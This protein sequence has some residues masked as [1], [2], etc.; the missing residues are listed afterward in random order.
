MDRP[1][2]ALKDLANPAIG[3]NNDS[4]LWKALALVRL[5]KWADA[6]EKFKNVEFAVPCLPIDLQRIAISDA[7]RAAVEVKDYS[8]AAQRSSD[9]DVIGLPD[10]M[11]PAIAVL[12]G[13]LAEALGHDMDALDNY[14]HAVESPDRAAAA[15]PN[16]V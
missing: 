1:A 12:R 4:Q 2:L 16:P 9:L 6:R 5:G 15:E 3:T 8:G 11:K 7:M 10:D 13:R 14:R